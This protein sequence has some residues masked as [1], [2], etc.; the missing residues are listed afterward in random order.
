MKASHG[1]INLFARHRVAANLLML[2]M[3]FVGL[4]ALSRLNTQF[5]PNFSLKLITINVVWPGASAQDIENSITTPIEKELRDIDHL[6]KMNS[7]SRLGAASIVLEFHKNANMSEA[8]EEVREQIA[9]IRNLPPNSEPPTVTRN[10]VYEPIAKL[11]ITGAKNLVELRPLIHR[12]ERELLDHGISKVDITG[13]PEQEIAIQIPIVRLT[14]LR[15]SLPQIA[16]RIAARSRDLPAGTVGKASVGRQLRSLSQRRDIKG[17]EQLPIITDEEGQLIRLGDIAT[18]QRRAKDDEVKV[19]YNGKAAVELTLL[20]TETANA[21]ESARILESWLQKIRGQLGS[22]VHIHVY[23]E[24]WTLITE[25]INLL[26]KNGAGGL[27]LILGILFLFLNERIAFWVAVGIPTSFMAALAVMYLVG[28]SINMVSLFALIMTLGIIVDDTI[29]V[30]EETLTN[31]SNGMPILPAVEAAAKKMLAPITASS[32]TTVCAFLPLMLIGNV[33]GQ[34]IFSIPLV[35]CCVIIASLLEC[36]LVLPGHLHHSLRNQDI[37]KERPFRQRINRLFDD[38]K[39]L[40]FRRFI[41][42]AIQHRFATLAAAFGL[43]II[44][45]GL[46]AGNLIHFNFFPAPEGKWIFANAQFTAGTPPAKIKAFITELE[47]TLNKTNTQLSDKDHDI[48]ETAVSYQNQQSLGNRQTSNGKGE[49]Y[50]S[51]AIELVSPDQRRITNKDFIEAWRKKVK[52]PAGIENFTII[53]P[54]GGPPG[55]DID[56]VLSNNDA[57]LLKSAS[58][59]L[60]HILTSFPGVSDISD[61]MPFAQEQLIYQLTATGKAL[62]L[63]TEAIGQQLRAA[64][65]GEI[66]QIYHEPNEEI[67]VRVMLPD[68]ERYRISSLEQLPILTP[69]GENVPLGTVVKFNY[70]RSP[71]ILRHNNTK[72]TVHV[73]AE[74]DPR[75]T[76]ANQ[77]IRALQNTVIPELMSRYDVK[78]HFEGRAEEQ[79][80]TF[81]D[82]RYGLILGLSL[83]YIILAWVFASYGWPLVVM[84][85]IPLG[86]TGAILGHFIMR[87]DLTIL[88]MF[89]IFGLSGIVVNDSI[90]LLNEYKQ[91][92]HMGLSSHDAIIEAS[93]KRLRAVLLTSL[94]TI[95]GLTPLL[96]ETSLQAQFLIPM[97]TSIAFG[98]GYATL[99]ILVVVPAL[100]SVYDHVLSRTITPIDKSI[101]SK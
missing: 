40:H 86:L 17:F 89:G 95:A 68:R 42:F 74:V 70:H 54:R 97:A 75:I 76:N 94:T 66:A 77:V 82:L 12:M 72:L 45:V 4:W 9:Q 31:L 44:T 91:M 6:K 33:I 71:N 62:G 47:T 38:F 46:V 73:N 10:Q 36:F 43:F 67:E 21:L 58:L 35:V 93:V 53:A 3:I 79:Q 34:I 88:S 85:V 5:M 26:L 49:Q 99:L 81:R 80:E 51:L 98:L 90:I 69:L 84:A 87:I 20:R 100:M 15:L 32:L 8:L 59:N 29:V 27:V 64:Y 65:N 13:L 7:T 96:F 14:E 50:A 83:I 39:Q 78:I 60:Q 56:I 25:R 11:V 24:L 28:D 57:G 48:L 63:T 23:Y 61:D 30:G 41:E 37:V 2:M 22:H 19:S 52:V 18:I 1:I 16:R 55:K 92:K 101:R